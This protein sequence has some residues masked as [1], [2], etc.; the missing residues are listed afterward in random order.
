MPRAIDVFVGSRIRDHRIHLGLTQEEL[1]RRIGLD[2]G[3]IDACESGQERPDPMRLMLLA[4]VLD[5]SIG[6]LYGFSAQP[7]RGLGFAADA[8]PSARPER[9]SALSWSAR[10]AGRAAV[11]ADQVDGSLDRN[12]H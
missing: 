3:E 10:R 9:V 1:G 2:P 12:R 5:C 8:E 11:A 6:D 7:L 4:A